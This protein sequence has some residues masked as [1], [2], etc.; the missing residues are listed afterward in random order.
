MRSFTLVTSESSP[1]SSFAAS[2]APM[3]LQLVVECPRDWWNLQKG[4][5]DCPRLVEGYPF[6]EFR[7]VPERL[8]ERGLSSPFQQPI[9]LGCSAGSVMDL[10]FHGSYF[11][12]SLGDIVSKITDIRRLAS[13][14][15]SLSAFTSSELGLLFSQLFLF[16]PVE[17]FLLFRHR[18]AEQGAFPSR[19]AFGPSWMPID[20]LIGIVGDIARIQGDVL[21]FVILRI[22]CGRQRTFRVPFSTGDFSLG[23]WPEGCSRV[24]PDLSSGVAKSSVHEPVLFL[25]PFL[26]GGKHLFKLLERHGV[27]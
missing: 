7:F 26:V 18:F 20:V 5:L 4:V 6:S 19:S 13:K 10:G 27:G 12:H 24:A 25:R 9:D 16:V 2:L 15:P 11:S 3:T 1:A 17:D 14:Y 22:F 21:D 23:F 8:S